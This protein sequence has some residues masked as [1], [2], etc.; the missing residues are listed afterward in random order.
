MRESI[1]HIERA[2]RVLTSLVQNRHPDPDDVAELRHLA[3]EAAGK[4]IDE[5]ICDVIRN[6]LKHRNAVPDTTRISG[7]ADE[8][9]RE[10][11]NRKGR[12]RC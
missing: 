1:E 9:V 3:P 2:A 7:E 5:I 8:G 4:T 6:A 11:E 12:D 10:S